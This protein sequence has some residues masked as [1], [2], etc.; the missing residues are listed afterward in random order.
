MLVLVQVA[1]LVGRR[2]ATVAGP[3][4]G[5]G[6]PA[7]GGEHPRAHGIHRAHLRREVGDV[8]PLRVLEQAERAGRVPLRG[9]HLGQRDPPPVGVLRQAGRLTELVGP[10][11]LSRRTGL[12]ATRQRH[13]AQLHLQVRRAPQRRPGGNQREGFAAAALGVAQ[14]ASGQFDVDDRHGAAQHV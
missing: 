13:P 8:D 4:K 12:V 5:L 3:R 9:A 14:P 2:E 1:Q 10:A 11:Q 6:H 7:G